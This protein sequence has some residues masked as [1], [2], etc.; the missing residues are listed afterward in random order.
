MT[1]YANI[2]KPVFKGFN[3]NWSV[4]TEESR[5]PEDNKKIINIASYVITSIEDN[6]SKNN[7]TFDD[8]FE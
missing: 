6:L 7:I 2:K 8:W 1:V 5:P 3:T 4:L